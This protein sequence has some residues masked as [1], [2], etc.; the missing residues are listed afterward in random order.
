MPNISSVPPNLALL[1]LE[2]SN[3]YFKN[4]FWLSLHICPVNI[5]LGA[6]RVTLAHR[7]YLLFQCVTQ[8]GILEE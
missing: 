8:A 5:C 2:P 4:I 6:D 1:S 7:K 3:D